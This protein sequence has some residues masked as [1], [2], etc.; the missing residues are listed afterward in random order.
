MRRRLAGTVLAAAL[1]CGHQL[2]E[3][4][5]PVIVGVAIGTAVA[6]GEPAAMLFWLGALAADFAFL[7]LCYRFGARAGARLRLGAAHDLR[8][9][10]VARILDPRGMRAADTG[11]VL[12][13]ATSDARRVGETVRALVSAIAALVAVVFAVAF[14]AAT[15]LL[16]ASVV[17]VGAVLAVTVLARLSRPL[18][19]RSDTEQSASA[20]TASL[21]AD[22]VAGLRTIKGLSAER[23][24][25]DRYRRQS[26]LSLGHA[27]HAGTFEG[28]L[29]G[30]AVAVVGL[31]LAVVAILG[32]ALA[33]SG[34]LGIGALIAVLGL[35]QFIVG[36][37]QTLGSFGVPLARGR[38]SAKRL[39]ALLARPVAL[40]GCAPLGAGSAI[41][42]LRVEQ[43]G[44]RLTG[45][46]I[47]GVVLPEPR[48]AVTLVD[49][50]AAE[51]L[52]ESGRVLLGDADTATTDPE[53]WRAVV[54]ATRHR[55]MLFDDTLAD[56]VLADGRAELWSETI[57]ASAV[58]DIVGRLPEGESTRLGEQGGRLSGGERQRVVL[59]RSLAADRDV[60]VLHDPTTAV[61]TVTEAIIARGI[62]R[63]RDSRTTVIIATSPALLESCDTVLFVHRD[64]VA[65]G[66]HAELA[67]ADGPVGAAYRRAVLR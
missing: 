41:A 67:S 51:A 65:E 18:E 47:T 53:A 3:A 45:G 38:A 59:G 1:L 62:R 42:D 54:L 6:T 12:T 24:A 4:L 60:L 30:V 15:S 28:T 33:L 36:P 40:T 5:V 43:F 49:L 22:L 17:A 10:V 57:V 14:V 44:L 26:R 21:G 58:D 25:S 19:R 39:D 11:E 23:A 32:A 50:L 63:M 46:R 16:L 34:A 31:Y 61:D 48:D 7:S 35:A 55:E 27:V 8:M 64:G 2:G 37:L 52:P 29:D 9:R 66:T 56:A 13:V 20:A